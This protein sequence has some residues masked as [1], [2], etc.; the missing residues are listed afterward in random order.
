MSKQKLTTASKK[1]QSHMTPEQIKAKYKREREAKELRERLRAEYPELY[2]AWFGDGE[3][4]PLEDLTGKKVKLNTENY[5]KQFANLGNPKFVKWYD[6]NRDNE[7]IV[8]E[9]VN[10]NIYTLVGV[11]LW[12]FNYFDLVKVE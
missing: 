7:F 2:D 12:H 8:E 5:D 11:E 10:K 4:E 9:Q 1:K 6:E 3:V